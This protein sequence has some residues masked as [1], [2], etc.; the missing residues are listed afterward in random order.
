MTD[1][2]VTKTSRK[3]GR[4]PINGR[5]AMTAA[6]RKRR[7]RRKIAGRS[8]AEG[9]DE[10]HETPA[11]AVHALLKAEDLPQRL[12]EPGCG[13]GAIVRVLRAT[14]RSVASSDH[15]AY[16]T[17][18]QDFV[19]DFLTATAAPEGT[20]AIVGN[21]PFSKAA[22]FVRH[23]LT[24]VPKVIMLL[25]LAFLEST[26]TSRLDIMEG[27]RLARVHVFRKRLPKM[28]RFGWTGKKASPDEGHAWFVWDAAH[29]GPP[30]V[31]WL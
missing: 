24:L 10:L 19:Q 21:P 9:G 22:E 13:Y 26:T 3:R 27:G 29:R 8:P 12:W 2:L 1:H 23:G 20:E 11:V 5:K 28:H 31:H 14:G 25:R 6:Q 4:P 30:T 15:R 18:D 17:P 16:D 7:Q